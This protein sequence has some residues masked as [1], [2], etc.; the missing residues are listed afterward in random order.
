MID[1]VALEDRLGLE[2]Y[3]LGIPFSFGLGGVFMVLFCVPGLMGFQTESIYGK[4]GVFV[5][6]SVA[7]LLLLAAGYTYRAVE[8][9]W[10]MMTKEQDGPG[11]DEGGQ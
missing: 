1:R 11:A 3:G 4:I 7:I 9:D 2:D 6:L 10:W 5:L 8:T